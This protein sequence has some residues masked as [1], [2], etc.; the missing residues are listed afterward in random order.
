M[1]DNNDDIN[2]ENQMR[3]SFHSDAQ[4]S[5]RKQYTAMIHD[6]KLVQDSIENTLYLSNILSKKSSNQF[7][8]NFSRRT[9][10]NDKNTSSLKGHTESSENNIFQS[11][12]NNFSP[13]TDLD[14]S[15]SKI[16]EGDRQQVDNIDAD[17][18]N[19]IKNIDSYTE[20]NNNDQIE[21][22]DIQ[23]CEMS[24][25]KNLCGDNQSQSNNYHQILH[26][27][28]QQQGFNNHDDCQTQSSEQH[29]AIQA[30]PVNYDQIET[31]HCELQ[32]TN[33]TQIIHNDCQTKSNKQDQLVHDAGLNNIDQID[34]EIQPCNLN[35]DSFQEFRK[36]TISVP[37]NSSYSIEFINSQT[38]NVV[39]DTII[40]KN[41]DSLT[42]DEST[43]KF[44][45]FDNQQHQGFEF[46]SQ[47][48]NK[49]QESE[50][51]SGNLRLSS[52]NISNIFLPNQGQQFRNFKLTTGE[53]SNIIDNYVD[54]I[55]GGE[56]SC[57]NQTEILI[58]NMQDYNKQQYGAKNNNN[59][60]CNQ[61]QKDD[62]IVK[63]VTND[64]SQIVDK[65]VDSIVEEVGCN[66]TPQSSDLQ[67]TNYSTQSLKNTNESQLQ[68][69][70]QDKQQQV[71][72]NQ[73][74][75]QQ[76]HIVK[77]YSYQDLN[78]NP[79]KRNLNPSDPVNRD[80][81]KAKKIESNLITPQ[82]ELN[83]LNEKFPFDKNSLKSENLNVEQAEIQ[84]GDQTSQLIVQNV[85][86]QMYK[87][88]SQQIVNVQAHDSKDNKKSKSTA[89]KLWKKLKK[90]VYP[91]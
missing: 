27:D 54:S 12:P 36:N 37:Q 81:Q 8:N 28:C 46:Q 5:Y 18:N 48:Q 39:N 51:K 16:S 76:Q 61:R 86:A 90:F 34:C 10:E 45:I 71:E 78:I 58:K 40:L 41:D 23:T 68:Q 11:C 42:N 50:R 20:G 80:D 6:E 85:N 63:R 82:A 77:N 24:T 84:Q 57:S 69:Y 25:E 26:S 35:Y 31:K 44:Q 72:N 13:Q 59:A 56:L 17:G 79:D 87:E 74:Q 22:I 14:N 49:N 1:Y 2:N 64:S 43:E 29:D 21:N 38:Q 47:F 91:S 65:C 89:K 83:F 75:L 66:S 30:E 32:D 7:D 3:Q 55:V 33:N 73:Q 9:T 70:M 15:F 62:G 60:N 88:Q 53:S 19:F 4:S 52:G 67:F